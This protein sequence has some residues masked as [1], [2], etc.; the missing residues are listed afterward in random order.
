MTAASLGRRSVLAGMGALWALRGVSARAGAPPLPLAWPGASWAAAQPALAGMDPGRLAAAVAHGAARGGSGLVVRGGY[1]VAGW[2]SQTQRYDLKSSTKSIGSLLLGLAIADRKVTLDTPVQPLLPEFGNPP[3]ANVAT[4]WLPLI[5]IRHLASH[6]AG[7]EKTGGYGRLLFQ[8]GTR[9]S[10]SDGGPNWIADLLTVAYAS[11]LKTVLQKRVLK[12]LGITGMMLTWRKNQ[13]REASLRGFVRREFG[14]GISA[15][16]DAMARLGLL[17][18]RDGQWRT[19]RILP[20]GFAAELGTVPAATLALPLYDP[21]RYP[22]AT[23]GYGYLWWS[24]SEGLL[25][26]VPRDAFWSWGLGDSF[27]LVVPSQDLVVARAGPSWGE[28]WGEL[29]AI[30]PF[31]ALV[32]G[33]VAA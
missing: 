3:A 17:V 20:A 30:Q 18:A 8:P 33:A 4:G 14:S 1:A 24:N 29:Q 31:F 12:D 16:V 2:G 26:G 6:T 21:K 23:Q 10:Y 7:F 22:G 15:S 13:Y 27:I 28:N 19:K 5:T 32:T 25:A 9:W 11:D